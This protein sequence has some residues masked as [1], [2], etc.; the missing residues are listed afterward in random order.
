MRH[1]VLAL[2]LALTASGC[3]LFTVPNP[4]TGRPQ[5]D[6]VGESGELRYGRKADHDLT[7]TVGVY[8]HEDFGR[9]VTE[10]G[11]A[12]ASHSERSQLPW[13]F[14]VLDD[15]A[16]NAFSVPG[17]YVY[18]TRGLLTHLNS[19][20]QLAAVIAHEVGHITA[21]HSVEQM[22]RGVLSGLGVGVASTVDPDGR[23]IGGFARAAATV[24]F[25][26]H[27]REDEYEADQLALRYLRRASWPP[28]A[29]PEVF[30][31]LG[32]VEEQALQGRQLP[33]L[34]RTHP[35]SKDRFLRLTAQLQPADTRSKGPDPAYLRRLDGMLFG[36]DPTE[37]FFVEETFVHPRLKLRMDFPVSWTRINQRRAV[38]AASPEGDALV[39]LAPADEDDP[40]AGLDAFEQALGVPLQ[41]RRVEQ[42]EGHAV[43]RAELDVP[44]EPG[45]GV[46]GWV[47]Y[48]PHG[49]QVF[50]LVGLC[51]QNQIP[52]FEANVEAWIRSFT[53]LRSPAA[54]AVQPM[55]VE[56]VEL[57]REMT[58][59][60]FSKTYPS[61]IDLETLT[62]INQADA[63]EPLERG[64]LVKRVTGFNPQHATKDWLK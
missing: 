62:I 53:T 29:L 26:S 59:E 28:G 58:L 18:V 19:D 64:R 24:S 10:I 1:A 8:E 6:L 14:R 5:L 40:S 32:R 13:T 61:V 20:E 35:T 38:L 46:R 25:L 23:G 44:A 34:L 41:N 45:K 17:G 30:D 11:A 48:V 27:S 52:R 37:G 57:K 36:A 7:Q 47:A 51:L 50:Q 16:V 33:T 60:E 15:P 43:H 3:C 54:L 56:I 49:G 2:C 42:R 9:R 63:S 22:S 21:R 12:L 39:R 4:A 55:R 31:V